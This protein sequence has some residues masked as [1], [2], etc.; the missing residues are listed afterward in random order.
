MTAAE[1][2]GARRCDSQEQSPA[3]RMAEVESNIV[4]GHTAAM[5]TAL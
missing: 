3:G 4:E 2:T 1:V 5:P